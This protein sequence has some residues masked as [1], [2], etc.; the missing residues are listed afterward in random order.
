MMTTKKKLGLLISKLVE[1]KESQTVSPSITE[2]TQVQEAC[3]DREWHS[4][5]SQ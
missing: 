2:G 1:K 3:A 4:R 5:V